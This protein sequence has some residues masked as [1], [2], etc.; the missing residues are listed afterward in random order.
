MLPKL[1]G[2]GKENIDVRD[3]FCLDADGQLFQLYVL[4]VEETV[5]F[6]LLDQLLLLI[7]CGR[8]RRVNKD[9]KIAAWHGSALNH[10]TRN[11]GGDAQFAKHPLSSCQNDMTVQLYLPRE[12][13][14][15]RLGG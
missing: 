4:C 14:P 8:M 7:A 1:D 6:Q 11:L 13:Q 2:V 3:V 10:A 15:F 5:F 9:A 12:R